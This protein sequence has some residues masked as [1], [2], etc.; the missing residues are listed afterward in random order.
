MRLPTSLARDRACSRLV[1]GCAAF[2]LAALPACSTKN[3]AEPVLRAISGHVVLRG[4]F[5]D[6][7]GRP[8]GTRVVGDADGVKIDLVRSNRVI[9]STTTVDG[10]YRFSGLGTGVYIA[11]TISLGGIHD[12]T[13]A[14]TIAVANV[15]VA[16]TLHMNSRGDL[17]PVPNPFVDSTAIYFE[18]PGTTFVE[19][20]IRDLAGNLVR[21]LIAEELPAGLQHVTWDGR[22]DHGAIAP[23]LIHWMVYEAGDDLRAHLLFR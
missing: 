14:L 15:A 12:T 22:D 13:E 17:Y 1:L 19:V 23:A 5:L 20:T 10:V 9:A 7:S 8:A 16:D 4:Y 6:A 21:S 3:P 18:V 2:M 11:G